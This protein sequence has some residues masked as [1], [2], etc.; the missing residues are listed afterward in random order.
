MKRRDV[1]LFPIALAGTA[2][3]AGQGRA[4]VPCPPPQGSVAGGSSASTSCGLISPPGTARSYSTSFNLTESPISEGGKWAKQTP[5]ISPG[6]HTGWHAIRTSGGNAVATANAGSERGGPGT[7]DYDDAYAYLS[8]SWAAHQECEATIHRG[9]GTP[10]EVELLLRCS[11]SPTQVR[12]YEC[13]FTVEDGWCFFARWNGPQD[14]FTILVDSATGLK[15]AE[16]I[17]PLQNGDRVRARIVGQTLTAWY[18]R[19]A[20]PTVWVQVGTFT[21]NSAGKLTAGAPGIGF[22]SREGNSLDYGFSD[23][24][25]REL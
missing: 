3:F 6:V 25:A 4:A 16:S 11:D 9:S 5:N 7:G 18:A 13:G 22:F 15:T 19:A 21:D 17:G 2:I 12:T 23:Y 1:V 24:T 8:G 14:D 10:R 20:T